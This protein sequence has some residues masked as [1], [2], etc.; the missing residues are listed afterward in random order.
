MIGRIG[1]SPAPRGLR[2]TSLLVGNAA[3]ATSAS[4]VVN[5]LHTE[6]L[7]RPVP[8]GSPLDGARLVSVE[9]LREACTAPQVAASHC[10]CRLT[11]AYPRDPSQRI[12]APVSGR[13][14]TTLATG[15]REARAPGWDVT[16]ALG[17][18][19]RRA[20][21]RCCAQCDDQRRHRGAHRLAHRARPRRLRTRP[22][23]YVVGDLLG[24]SLGV[25]GHGPPVSPAAAQLITV[26]YQS[27]SSLARRGGSLG[28][29]VA[30][31]WVFSPG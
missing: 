5:P 24:G 21:V 4:L 19:G 17:G 29:L 10:R 23:A 14:G 22:R 27:G 25:G 2:L 1:W 9:R 15:T 16:S 12:I 28:R 31:S 20:A 3:C 30:V 26:S 6:R 18:R 13:V 7:C 11:T 8:A